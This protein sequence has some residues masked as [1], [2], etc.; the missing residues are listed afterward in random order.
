MKRQKKKTIKLA[1]VLAPLI[2]LAAIIGLLEIYVAVS[3]ID[4]RI[5][6]APHVIFGKLFNRFG[7]DLSRDFFY[8]LKVILTGYCI[9]IPGG[10]GLAAICSQSKLLSKA[11]TPVI[12]LMICIPMLTVVPI[13]VLR[14]GLVIQVRII[15]VVLQALPVICLNTLSGF[16]KVE[17]SKIELFRSVGASRWQIF[18]KL[19]FPN[20]MPQVF[21]GLKLGCIFSTIAAMGADLAAGNSGLG[22]KISAY[23][24]SL[25][26]DMAYATIIVVALI[27]IILFMVVAEIEKKIVVWIK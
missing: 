12:I 21:T 3:G 24:G 14:M 2:F 18:T 22:T 20:A 17:S 27:G 13:L 9:A 16:R 6:P 10:I 5:L 7:R 1:N 19:I 4:A 11:I 25:M 8:T 23:S 26:T 15:A